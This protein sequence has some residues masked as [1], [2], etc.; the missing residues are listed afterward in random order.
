MMGGMTGIDLLK[1]V[2]QINSDTQVII[3]TSN[4]SLDTAIEALRAGAYD[5]L[6]KSFDDINIIS[7]VTKRAVDKINLILENTRLMEGMKQKNEELEKINEELEG[8]VSRAGG[9]TTAGEA[10]PSESKAPVSKPNTTT[11]QA[12]TIHQKIELIRKE[13]EK[14]K[15]EMESLL[16]NMK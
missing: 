4:A 5:Y 3:M 9:Q 6:F 7:V 12:T 16:K 2:K 14:V 1:K 10:A 13:S 11:I 8:I 15:T